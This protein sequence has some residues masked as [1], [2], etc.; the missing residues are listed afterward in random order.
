MNFGTRIFRSDAF[1]IVGA[2]HMRY[3]PP[4]LG[5]RLVLAQALIDHLAQQIVVVPGEILHFGDQ[6]GPHPMHAAENE[7]RAEA[8]GARRRYLQ[9]RFIGSKRLQAAPQPFELGGC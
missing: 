3:R 4:D 5:R 8:A 6:L 2:S 7:R 9:R 1:G